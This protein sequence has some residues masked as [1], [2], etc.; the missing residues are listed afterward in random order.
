MCEAREMGVSE[1]ALGFLVRTTEWTVRSFARTQEREW[2]WVIKVI[3][4]VDLLS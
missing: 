1:M 4:A 2:V 3:S